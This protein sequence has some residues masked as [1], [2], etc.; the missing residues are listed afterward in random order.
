[1]VNSQV[2]F[3]FDLTKAFDLVD[4]YLLL[5]KPHA[6]GLSENAI[7]WFNSFLHNRKQC[8]VLHGSRSD[9]LIQQRVVP[10]GSTLGPLLFSIYV[11][12]LPSILTNCCALTLLFTHPKLTYHKFKP[13][14]N[15][16]LT[17]Y[18]TSFHKTNSCSIRQSPRSWFLVPDRN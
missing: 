2:Q 1:M 10:K 5:D 18:K 16:I 12:N 15:L 13:P 9:M 8:V 17:S 6:I 14:F 4:H 7:L 3:F 11:N